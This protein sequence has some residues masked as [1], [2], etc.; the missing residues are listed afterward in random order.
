MK[1]F[2]P[3]LFSKIKTFVEKGQFIIVG[4]TWVEMVSLIRNILENNI[5][6]YSW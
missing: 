3:E 5:E 2:Y 6:I 4:G 1:E